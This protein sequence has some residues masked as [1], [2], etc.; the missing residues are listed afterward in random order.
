[1]AKVR[2]PTLSELHEDWQKKVDKLTLELKPFVLCHG[3]RRFI[4]EKPESIRTSN[5]QKN[6][7]LDFSKTQRTV[8]TKQVS[9]ELNIS[10]STAH[11]N[12]K[13]LVDNGLMKRRLYHSKKGKGYFLYWSIYA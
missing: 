8:S 9:K 1:M 3:K 4:L 11:I 7:I 13:T 12:L 6:R 2:S 5:K 10:L